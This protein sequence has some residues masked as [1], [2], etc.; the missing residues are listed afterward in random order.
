MPPVVCVV[1]R[2]GSGKTRIIEGIAREMKARGHRVATVARSSDGPA[3]QSVT[4]DAERYAAAGS[5][6]YALYDGINTI[7]VADSVIQPF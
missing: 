6:T 4:K 1:G 3:L 7:A 5:E 2:D